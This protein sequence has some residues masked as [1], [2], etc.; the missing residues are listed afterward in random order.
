MVLN[1]LRDSIDP[2]ITSIGKTLGRV[3]ISPNVLTLIGFGFA[4]LAGL[5][6]SVK[7]GSPYLAGISI[8]ASGVFDVLDGAVARVTSQITKFGS[9]SDSTLDRLSEVFIFAGIIFGRY[10][11]APV[12]VLLALGFS[13][14][15][16]Y[17]RAKSDALNIK[18]SGIGIG[19][20]AERLIALAILSIIGF[21]NYGVYLVLILAAVTFVQRYFVAS[22]ALRTNAL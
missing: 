15:V 21:V 4:V 5:L 6:Y 2:V 16:S 20:R 14:L 22:K 1:R 18:M 17:V 9:F 7:T 12:W 11:I 3:G 13:L 19:E 8:L 10:Q